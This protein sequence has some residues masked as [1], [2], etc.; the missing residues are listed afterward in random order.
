MVP[1]GLGIPWRM[2]TS[3]WPQAVSVVQG[4]GEKSDA[5]GKPKTQYAAVY[6]RLSK[7][8]VSEGPVEET[9]WTAYRETTWYHSRSP[10]R[11]YWSPGRTCIS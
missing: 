5:S 9:K 8:R 3:R 4:V 7:S 6:L 11:M 1:S 2:L 10:E